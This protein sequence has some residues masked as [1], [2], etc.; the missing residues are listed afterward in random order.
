MQSTLRITTTVQPGNRIEITS[1]QL[2]E[3]EAIE[4]ILKLPEKSSSESK[5]ALD[6]ISSLQ[7][8]RIFN[9]PEEVDEYVQKE[10]ESWES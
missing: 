2:V 8:H 5:S 9:S 6:I 10:R 7:G 1:P 4:V 3:G